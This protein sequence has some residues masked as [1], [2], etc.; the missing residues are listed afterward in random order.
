[1]K[2]KPLFL[3]VL[4]LL[5]SCAEKQ[6]IRH[7]EEVETILQEK[8][9]SALTLL[10]AMDQSTIRSKKGRALW[11]LLTSAALDKN[12]ID[13]TSDSLINNAVNYYSPKND[14][15]HRMLAYY[16]QGLVDKN[17]KN[18]NYAIISFEKALSDAVLNKDYYYLGLIYRN[19]AEV[20]NNTDNIPSA[21][22]NIQKSIASFDK[23]KKKNYSDYAK[24][25]LVYYYYN[26]Q[27]Y[28]EALQSLKDIDNTHEIK[29]QC[30]KIE[31]GILT[32]LNEDLER[33]IH[34]FQGVSPRLM[35]L[36]DCS[37]YALALESCNRSAEA[38]LWLAEAYHRSSNVAK[39]GEVEYTHGRIEEL[40]GNYE[41]AY[42]LTRHASHVQDSVIRALLKESVTATQ[43]DFYKT[44]SLLQKEKADR[45]HDRLLFSI[46][47]STLLMI[48]GGLYL[49]MKRNE[50][51][52]TQKEQMLEFSHQ[53]Q[54][55]EKTKKD[56]AALLGSLF[57]EK[58]NHL[59]FIS[60][61]YLKA[62]NDKDKY[63]AFKEFKAEIA[64]MRKDEDLFA[65]LERDLN[66]Y[67]DGIM[68]KLKQQVPS[69]KGENKKIIMLFFANLPYDTVQ[70]V[71]NKNSIDSLRTTRS[72]F[73]KAIKAA[74]APDAELFLS[75][76]D[77]KQ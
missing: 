37:L 41:A 68:E 1:M 9:D 74:D 36:H 20:F 35:N 49:V 18:Y 43:R 30:Q 4:F 52:R 48:I 73:R 22:E 27:N 64:A 29:E 77:M 57:R 54:Q 60:D 15:H 19:I 31:A 58:L 40:R 66:L 65:S 39:K 24:L 7:L 13:V 33:A 8:P 53:Q 46:L 42:R 76:L 11:A 67:C 5:G 50:A 10:Q 44:E 55:L 63:Q 75:M 23:A 3:I 2:Y 28:T 6:E 25:A 38:D 71:L 45:T 21:I 14:V 61:S 72:R 26:N 16:Y 32:I 59:D 34:L 62:E 12:Y 47:I 70:L 51:D 56:N 69:I 17:A